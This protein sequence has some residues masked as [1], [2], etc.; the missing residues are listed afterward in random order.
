LRELEDIKMI[1]KR[2]VWM[3]KAG[4]DFLKVKEDLMKD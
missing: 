1:R 3:S 2:G 4:I